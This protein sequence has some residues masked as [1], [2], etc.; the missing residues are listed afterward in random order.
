M[1]VC[2]P[3]SH[4][5]THSL[6]LIPLTVSVTTATTTRPVGSNG[7]RPSNSNS[8]RQLHWQTG[9][10]V[11]LDD[12]ANDSGQFCLVLGE[13]VCTDLGSVFPTSI[14]VFTDARGVMSQ[15]NIAVS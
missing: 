3:A 2:L 15:V 9:F 4:T 12:F 14:V 13:E 10:L 5:H 6:S 8:S 1:Q 11:V 7:R